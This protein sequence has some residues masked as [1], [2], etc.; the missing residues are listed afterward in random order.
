MSL[1]MTLNAEQSYVLLRYVRILK[2]QKAMTTRNNL[3]SK[4]EHR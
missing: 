2:Y 3:Y 1:K 4:Y